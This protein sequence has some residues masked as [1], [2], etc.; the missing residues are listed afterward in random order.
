MAQSRGE[1][2][3]EAGIWSNL[4]TLYGMLG[5]WP[6]A[7]E[8]LDN[9]HALMPKE[10]RYRPALLAQRVR[11]AA[12]RPDQAGAGFAR[13]WSEAMAEA[14]QAGNWQA[15]RH[16]WDEAAA[17]HVSAGRQAEAG[18]AL[19]NAFRI[20]KLHKLPDPQSLWMLAGLLALAEGRP[21]EAMGWFARVR[22][23]SGGRDTPVNALRLAAAEARAEAAARGPEA[24]L[25]SCRRSWPQV[26]GWRLRVPP[27]PLV[28]LAVDVA[29]TELVD[30]Y[31][32]AA[33]A[34]GGRRGAV[35]AWWVLEQSRALGVLRQRRRRE[36]ANPGREAEM[37]LMETALGPVGTPGASGAG[38]MGGN[39][40]SGS[41][42]I[43]TAHPAMT[44]ARFRNGIPA[45]C[46]SSCR[47]GFTRNGRAD[48]AAANG[49]PSQSSSA[50]TPARRARRIRI[51]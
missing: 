22:G 36:D 11:V 9:A 29:V 38:G 46:A 19:A 16:L 51:A 50:F 28:E 8:A 37:R 2:E 27:D 43:R 39:G 5:A 31:I 47:L 26:L 35:E 42:G 48:T 13:L 41:G 20:A 1:A 40:D 6:M 34:G 7:A 44:P 49:A 24:A 23:N 14:E 45:H 30:E 3:T 4:A 21:Q 12:R 15:Q 33:L 17:Y 32:G 25:E 18:A 10:S